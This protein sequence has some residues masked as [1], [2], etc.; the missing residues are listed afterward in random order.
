MTSQIEVRIDV[1]D[2]AGFGEAAYIAASIV[3]PDPALIAIHPIVAFAKPAGGYARAYYTSELPGPAKGAQAAFHAQHGWVFV[4]MDNLGCGGSS[5]HDPERLDFRALAAAALAAEQDILLRLANGVLAAD[6]PPINQ[7]VVIGMGQSLGGALTIYQQAHHRCYDGIAILGFSAVHSHPLTP[8][9]E[10]PIVVPWFARD[11][12]PGTPASCIN[13]D[14]VLAATA[15]GPQE[16]AWA[17]LAWG[18]HFDDVPPDVVERDLLHYEAIAQ[19]TGAPPGDELA[20]WNS[21]NTPERAARSTLTPGVVAPEAAAVTVPVLS[22]MGL[23]DLIPDP[24]GESRAFRSAS[25]MDIFIC[26]RMG[27]MHNFASTRALFWQRID[28][29]GDWCAVLKAAG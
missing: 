15:Q 11:L 12:M 18:F 23:R 27:H 21:Y 26:P 1:S 22:A 8:P 20:P 19:G 5:R 6:Y 16:S 10:P 9:G 28:G 13:A 24:Q 25:S 17:S 14:A 4:A 7:P 29:F 3:L 2:A